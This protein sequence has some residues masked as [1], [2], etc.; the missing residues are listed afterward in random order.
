MARTTN[1]KSAKG[2]NGVGDSVTVYFD[3]IDPAERKALEAARLLA[4]KHGRRK[5]AIVALLEA[6]YNHYEATGQL[7]SASDISGALAGTPIPMHETLG[8]STGFSSKSISSP[9][10]ASAPKRKAQRRQSGSI[11]VSHTG[12]SNTETIAANF[13]R[14]VSGIASGFFD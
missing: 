8:T 11:E 10:S 14:S 5:Q 4:A 12:A 13:L 9:R 6:I 3:P 2:R 1:P 7:M